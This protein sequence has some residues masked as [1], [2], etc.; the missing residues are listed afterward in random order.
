MHVWTSKYINVYM[1]VYIYLSIY[2]SIIPSKIAWLKLSGNFPAGLGIPPLESRI[3]LESNP[4]KSRILVWILAE[5]QSTPQ[6]SAR[7]RI[8]ATKK[9]R[10][11]NLGTFLR[12]GRA[13]PSTVRIR[14]GRT[15]QASRF[16]LHGW[17]VHVFASP[18]DFHARATSEGCSKACR[19]R[20]ASFW[21]HQ[22]PHKSLFLRMAL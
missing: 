22:L 2:L 12:L 21:R 1:C 8:P 6:E 19:K 14:T 18:R 15:P 13:Q 17:G 10:R 16:L 4:L 5:G 11:R 7:L 3:L 9:P 20:C